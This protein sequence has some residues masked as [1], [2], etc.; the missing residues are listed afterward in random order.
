MAKVSCRPLLGFSEADVSLLERLSRSRTESASRVLRARALLA[1]HSGQ[2]IVSVARD[3]GIDRR[4]IDLTIQKALYFGLEGA[5]DDLPR[6]GRPVVLTGDARAWVVSL[7]CQKPVDLGY[8]YELWSLQLLADH[9]REHCV[10]AGHSCLGKV[11]RSTI[12]DILEADAV[13][14]HKISYYLER[15]D[16]DFEPKMAQVLLAYKDVE[17]YR[18]DGLPPEYAAVLSYDE[19]PGI[20]AVG[21][22]APDLPAVPGKHRSLARD[23]EYVR[24]GTV[25]LLG[26]IDLVTGEAFG[27]VRDRH[28]SAEFIEVLDLCDARYAP[29]AKIRIILDNHS[30]HVSKEVQR[31]LAAKPDRFEFVFTPKH[32]SWLNIVE[33]FFAKMTNTMLRGLRVPSKEELARR[34]ELYLAEVNAKPVVFKWKYKL[35]ETVN[36]VI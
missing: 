11:V 12:W 3:L 9:V 33:S 13:K 29:N 26:G 19:K 5:L 35:E 22:T 2:P 31:Y 23:Y 16:P 8:S 7:A 18:K 4:R 32:G 17:I 6:P 20:Q 1:F 10:A 27:L 34:I 15:R 28:R 24:H 30:A 14:P 25:S 36:A 21:K